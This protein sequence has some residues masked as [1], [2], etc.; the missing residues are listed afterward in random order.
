MPFRL[1]L[2]TLL[3]AAPA[4]AEDQ[5]QGMES[6]IE[7]GGLMVMADGLN[8]GQ[9]ICTT[10]FPSQ[11]QVFRGLYESSSVP[12]Y[13][14]AFRF[15]LPSSLPSDRAQ[16]LEKL[17]KTESEVSSGCLEKYPEAL[18]KFDEL[19]AK[20]ADEWLPVIERMTQETEFNR[21]SPP[22][23]VTPELNALFA[24][25]V[26]RSNRAYRTGDWSIL[27]DLYQPETFDCWRGVPGAEQFEFLSLGPLSENSTYEVSE[28]TIYMAGNEFEFSHVEPTHIM[29]FHDKI[30]TPGARCGLEKFERYPTGHFFLVQRGQEFHLTHY[31]PTKE[32]VAAGEVSWDRPRSATQATANIAKVNAADWE[33]IAGNIKGDRFN[34]GIQF[35]LSEKYGFS[36]DEA[37]EVVRYVCDPANT[38]P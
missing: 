31:C 16:L 24:Q 4:V 35:R 9:Q 28:F 37:D 34:S 30:S 17:G 27:A 13:V 19:Y 5:P 6:Y 32:A 38:P 7:F 33:A 26:E 12:K 1:G 15:E 29:E 2:C 11:A 23:Q 22:I 18:N 8:K 3:L 10:L 21:P 20:R 36:Y 25:I 14:K